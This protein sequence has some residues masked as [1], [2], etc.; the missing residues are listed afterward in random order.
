MTHAAWAAT[1]IVGA[2]GGVD[3]CCIGGADHGFEQGVAA[4]HARI[5][6]TDRWGIGA[7]RRGPAT[8]VINPFGLLRR[9]R[10]VES[11]R[12]HFGEPEL[13]EIVQDVDRTGELACGRFGENDDSIIESQAPGPHFEPRCAR[14]LVE[15]FELEAIMSAQPDFPPDLCLLIWEDIF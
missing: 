6:D 14:E 12:S 1:I 2:P 5:E 7:T 15:A 10:I 11:S 9:C 8:Q 13:G 4:V 3:G